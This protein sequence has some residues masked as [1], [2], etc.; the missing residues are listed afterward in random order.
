MEIIP[1]VGFIKRYKPLCE[2]RK[3]KFLHQYRR[4]PLSSVKIPSF[5]GAHNLMYDPVKWYFQI[6]AYPDTFTVL[7]S[8]NVFSFSIVLYSF[9]L[10]FSES[11]NTCQRWSLSSCCISCDTFIVSASCLCHFVNINHHEIAFETMCDFLTTNKN[12]ENWR[13]LQHCEVVFV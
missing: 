9:A 12:T 5:P 6:S 2:L 7:L 3:K 10:L 4:L 13:F 11:E 8:C 1:I